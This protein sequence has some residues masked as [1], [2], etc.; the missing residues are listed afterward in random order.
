MAN[1]HLNQI[2]FYLNDNILRT[3]GALGISMKREVAKNDI[4][5]RASMFAG[6]SNALSLMVS[7]KRKRFT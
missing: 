6:T 4:R 2:F 1:Q 7:S 3:L 5:L